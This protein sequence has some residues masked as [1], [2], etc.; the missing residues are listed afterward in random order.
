MRVGRQ[1]FVFRFP[2]AITGILAVAAMYRVGRTLFDGTVAVVGA[3]LLA[4]SSF[5][6]QYSQEARS[7]SLTALLA[8]ASLYC[9]YRAVQDNRFKHWAG[10]AVI[11][12]LSLANHLTAASVVASDIAWAVLVLL[13]ERFSRSDDRQGSQAQNHPLDPRW[14]DCLSAWLRRIR[15]SRGVMLA[16]SSTVGVLLALVFGEHWISFLSRLGMSLGA[17]PSVGDFEA[18]RLS[19]SYLGD[20]VAGF[21]AGGGVALLLFGVAFAAGLVCCAVRRQW[22]QLLLAPVWM[23]PPFLIVPRITSSAP[24]VPRHL[25]FI[26]PLYLLFVA[27][28]IA[29]VSELAS[30]YAGRSSRARGLASVMTI[31][32][33]LGTISWLSVK[34]V[35]A[36]YREQKRD[37]RAAAAFLMDRVEPGDLVFE[38][39][40][41]HRD[42]VTY[43][44]DGNRRG[45][46]IEVVNFDTVGERELQ[47]DVWWV[48]R[49]NSLPGML[50]LDLGPEFDVHRLSQ[51]AI[52]HRDTPVADPADFWQLTTRLLLIQTQYSVWQELD[53]YRGHLARAYDSPLQSPVPL[54]DCLPESSDLMDHVQTL[55]EQIRSGQR[56]RAL[57]T[58][59][60]MRVLHQALY[61]PG[62]ELDRSALQALRSLGGIALDSGDRSCA[63]E[64]YS[65]AAD[66]LLLAVESDPGDVDGWRDLANVLVEAERYPEAIEAYQRLIDLVPDHTRYRIRLARAYRANGQVDEAIAVL[67]RAIELA[68]GEWRPLLE[69]GNTYL[70]LERTDEAAAAFQRVLEVDAE[71]VEAHF[72]LALAYDAQGRTALANH[73]YETVIE[74]DPEHWLARQAEERLAEPNQ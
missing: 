7:Y 42:A 29:G 44:L 26:L 11:T 55:G 19:G 36:Y 31:A 15:S 16:F 46:G 27:R 25:I 68:P 24:F 21:G 14:Q 49:N 5:H 60:K 64:L 52:I 20:F 51:V 61:P 10:F 70:L 53:W 59:Q 22:R 30:R 32:L 66:G 67:E 13:G 72:G 40:L 39:M 62:E 3:F 4:I 2:Y 17:P 54:P 57:E 45:V 37:W 65:R 1:E 74:I 47:V 34:P 63:L 38:L 71:V 69:L 35:Q 43:Y 50:E 33:V 58:L 48:L 41:W 6:I 73:Q 28:G 8:L 9:L 18:M 23:L 12:A 56:L